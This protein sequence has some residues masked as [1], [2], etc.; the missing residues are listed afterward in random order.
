MKRVIKDLLIITLAGIGSSAFLIGSMLLSNYRWWLYDC[1]K[2][3]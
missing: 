2:K 3:S 1:T